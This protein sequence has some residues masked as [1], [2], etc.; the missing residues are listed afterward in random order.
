MMCAT[1]LLMAC[2][3]KKIT[4]PPKK[5]PKTVV[6]KAPEVKEDPSADRAWKSLQKNINSSRLSTAKRLALVK[7]FV[8]NYGKSKYG[9]EARQLLSVMQTSGKMRMSTLMASRRVRQANDKAWSA[10]FAQSVKSP[11]A[12]RDLMLFSMLNAGRSYSM[13][14]I[15]EFSPVTLSAPNGLQR[16]ITKPVYMGVGTARYGLY[17]GIREYFPEMIPSH[18]KYMKDSCFREAANALSQKVFQ[19]P[20]YDAPAKLNKEAVKKA[21]AVLP[22]PEK[23]GFILG[24]AEAQL[25]QAYKPLMTSLAV[26]LAKLEKSRSKSLKAYKGAVK[27]H[28]A[29]AQEDKYNKEM[30]A[31]YDQFAKKQGIAEVMPER[32]G[33]A[34]VYTGFWLRR[35]A[36]GTDKMFASVLKNYVRVYD[37]P[38]YKKLF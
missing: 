6:K 27:K 31:F 8:R 32:P 11:Q 24:A 36:D 37:K 1:G 25:Y 13:L 18:C 30:L 14:K 10:V 5:Q 29:F 23:K 4:P 22:V 26:S 7:G 35:M 16:K 17:R 15:A 12:Y 34:Y 9:E 3:P 38:L 20:L 2:E 21:L 19:T 33:Y 28:K